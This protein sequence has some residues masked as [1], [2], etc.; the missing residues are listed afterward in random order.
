MLLSR[1]FIVILS[2][3]YV[4]L[5]G[6]IA[7]IFMKVI[8]TKYNPPQLLFL[9]YF[10]GFLF[11]IPYFIS[12]G[13]IIFEKKYVKTYFITS[14]FYAGNIFCF[15]YGIQYTTSTVSQIFYLLSPIYVSLISFL[16]FHEHVSGR[17]I[18]S[19]TLGIIGATLIVLRSATPHA[20]VN[21]IGTLQGNV[22]IILGVFSWALYIVYTKKTTFP[23]PSF[24]VTVWNLLFSLI[25]SFFF[26]LFAKIDPIKTVSSLF[27]AEPTVL[28]SL[29][30]LSL[31][32]TIIIVLIYQ[33]VIKHSSAFGVA[34]ASYLSP[35]SAA[36]LGIS[37]FGEKLSWILIIG[38]LSIFLGSYLILTEKK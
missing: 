28:G 25:L 37:F 9:R 13:K 31:L 22:I 35:L 29:F 3:L 21:S 2:L 12:K 15:A 5:I 34:S 38:A 7:P 23:P 27:V 36:M 10:F 1:R 18:Y 33:W 19:M 6:G 4:G 30:A 26:L 20:L 24:A 32:N 8:L 11:F 17:R 16:Y 14:L